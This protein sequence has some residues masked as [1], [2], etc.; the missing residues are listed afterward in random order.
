V[1]VLER[2]RPR[3]PHRAGHAPAIRGARPWPTL[4]VALPERIDETNAARVLSL[5]GLDRLMPVYG[6][7]AAAAVMPGV[8]RLPTGP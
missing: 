2:Q 7:V 8:R 6:D 4:A 3:H 5:N 1:S